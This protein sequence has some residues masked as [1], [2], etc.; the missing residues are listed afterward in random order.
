MVL[1]LRVLNG[2]EKGEFL[3]KLLE[4]ILV[5]QHI[6]QILFMVSFSFLT[7]QV[8]HVRGSQ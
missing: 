7:L 2:L 6:E 5:T 1:K 4:P 8:P 3:F